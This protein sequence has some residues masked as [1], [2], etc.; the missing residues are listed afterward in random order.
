MGQAARAFLN[1]L[2]LA[3][4]VLL[5]QA[6]AA[7]PLDD[8]TRSGTLNIAV[9]RDNPP[10]SF[11]HQGELVGIDIDL[12][13][14]VAERLGVAPSYMEITA[15]ETMD[16]DLRNAVWKGHYISRSVADLMLGVPY[17]PAFGQRN[18]EIALF[19]PYAQEEFVLVSDPARVGADPKLLAFRAGKI[20][21]ELNSLPDFFLSTTLNGTLRDS[22]VHVANAEAAARELMQARVAGAMGTRS[23]LEW[24]LGKQLRQLQV[25]SADM[26]GFGR[27]RWPIGVAVKENSRDLGYAAEDAIN[28][29]VASGAMAAIYRAHGASYRPAPPL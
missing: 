16:D 2:L 10:F 21:V 23:G 14:L 18:P 4:V 3:G 29:V 27:T 7:R 8:V 13:R 12:G 11:H 5:G 6:A 25:Q 24:A 20:A 17:D 15:G 1:G 19:A 26:S 22:V 28:E 9:Y